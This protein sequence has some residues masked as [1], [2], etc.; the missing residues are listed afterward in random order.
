MWRMNFI[1]KK[2]FL[3]SNCFPASVI[4]PWYVNVVNYL[5]TN[6]LPQG[7]SKAQK[8]KIKSD[9]KYYVWDDLYL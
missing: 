4:L 2:H 8:D 1:C 5:V 7:M 3:T 9:D 6:M